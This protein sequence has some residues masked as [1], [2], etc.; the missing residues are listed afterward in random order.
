MLPIVPH[1]FLGLALF[2]DKYKTI[3][4]LHAKCQVHSKPWSHIM[5]VEEITLLFL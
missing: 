5:P 2:K 1:Y 4:F 3:L